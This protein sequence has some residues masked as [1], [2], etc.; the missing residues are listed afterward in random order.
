VI[1]DN[2]HF[3]VKSQSLIACVNMTYRLW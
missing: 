1:L 2:C 3:G